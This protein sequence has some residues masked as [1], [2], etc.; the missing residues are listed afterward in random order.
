[1]A[2]RVAR[3]HGDARLDDA[4]RLFELE[5]RSLDVVGEVALEERERHERRI[6]CV[7]VRNVRETFAPEFLQKC[8]EQVDPGGVERF[9]GR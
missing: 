6:R 5:F 8:P 3:R 1:M 9:A 7:R 2:V 4:P